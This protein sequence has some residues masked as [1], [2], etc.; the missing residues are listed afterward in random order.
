M[1]YLMQEFKKDPTWSKETYQ[2]VARETGLSESQVYKWGWDQKNKK[3]EEESDEDQSEKENQQN[4]EASDKQSKDM[5]LL[6]LD[7]AISKVKI[8]TDEMNHGIM[9]PHEIHKKNSEIRESADEGQ[10]PSCGSDK[11]NQGYDTDKQKLIKLG[12]RPLGDVSNTDLQSQTRT[13]ASNQIKKRDS[14]YPFQK[15]SGSEATSKA[16][17]ARISNSNA[18]NY[19]YCQENL[20]LQ[21]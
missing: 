14:K 6:K 20:D 12:K 15:D 2:R 11:A 3:N 16:K 10:K 4:D 18:T 21:N 9:L 13:Q 17:T 8:D 19:R 7:L 5:K 1:R